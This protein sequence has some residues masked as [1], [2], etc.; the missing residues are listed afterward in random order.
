MRVRHA[1]YLAREFLHLFKFAVYCHIDD[2]KYPSYLEH[3]HK[4]DTHLFA[5][6]SQYRPTSC[7]SAFGHANALLTL[8]ICPRWKVFRS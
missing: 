3:W 2:S 6:H 7:P 1:L 4:A 8:S 5:S